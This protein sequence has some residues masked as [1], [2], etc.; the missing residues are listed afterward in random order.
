MLNLRYS[1]GVQVQLFNIFSF[2]NASGTKSVNKYDQALYSSRATFFIRFLVV[3]FN[4]YFNGTFSFLVHFVSV[5]NYHQF[6]K[7]STKAFKLTRP[8][9]LDVYG[10]KNVRCCHRFLEFVFLLSQSDRKNRKCYNA[11]IDVTLGF[12]T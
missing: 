12:V 10:R 1:S 7:W 2:L 11:N 6:K 4:V 9:I 5:P 3:C 8:I